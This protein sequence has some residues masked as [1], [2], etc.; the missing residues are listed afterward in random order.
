MPLALHP[1]VTALPVR[2][3]SAARSAWWGLAGVLVLASIVQ[4]A[5]LGLDCDV[6]W[7]LT[8]GERWLGGARLYRDVV[9]VNPPA[10]VLLYS[11][12]IVIGRA[13]G[14]GADGATVALAS[15]LAMVVVAVTGRALMRDG[16]L[17]RQQGPVMAVAAAFVFGVLPAA[18]FAQREHVAV[19]LAL[20][21]LAVIARRACG[22]P[23]ARRAALV[24]GAAGGMAIA[25]KP[26]F[27]LAFALPV[28]VAA[29]RRRSLRAAI[30][31]EVVAASVVVVGYGVVV[32][33]LFPDYMAM[34]PI[35]RAVY[36]PLRLDAVTLLRGPVVALPVAIG[37]LA[38]WVRG[39]RMG[40]VPAVLGA[41]ALGFAVAGVVQGKGYLNHAYPAAA[42]GFLALAVVV[43]GAGPFRR[44]RAAAT[45]AGV[46]LALLEWHAF[47]SIADHPGLAEA[48]ARVAPPHPRIAALTTEIGVG[49][50]LVRQLGG[51]WVMR[52][53]AAWAAGGAAARLAAGGLAP[54]ERRRL[55]AIGA[56]DEA[57][58]VA[59]VTRGRPDVVLVDGTLS[60]WMRHPAVAGVLRGYRP[61]AV[62]GDVAIWTRRPG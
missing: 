54:E 13:T 61:S 18:C 29:V 62:V 30:G 3:R 47:A 8:V 34:L 39:A 33:T 59:D 11:P 43:S 40:A 50:P 58:F 53:G 48:V 24:A 17:A 15:M 57:A 44:S 41:A 46:A 38:W 16:V 56:A 23:V 4:Q 12:A 6:S 22:M 60:D 36:L 51:E 45:L 42:L 52:S 20:P 19:L 49:H 55:V 5:W 26:H 28:M 14:I 35:L 7:L 31:A 21:A 9:E 32:L 2:P 10:S 37:A 25:I 1:A 27:A